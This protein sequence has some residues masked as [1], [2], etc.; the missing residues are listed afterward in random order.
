MDGFRDPRGLGGG[1]F[2]R[3]LGGRRR[4][5]R[6]ANRLVGLGL[7]PIRIAVAQDVEHD[8]H[9]R[10]EH[11][12]RDYLLALEEQQCRR[13]APGI[14]AQRRSHM[15]QRPDPEQIAQ[16]KRRNHDAVHRQSGRFELAHQRVHVAPA[17]RIGRRIRRLLGRSR[18][19]DVPLHVV[20][21]NRLGRVKGDF[22]A[23]RPIDQ[24]RQLARARLGQRKKP[25]LQA[26]QRSN[27]PQGGAVERGMEIGHVFFQ[28]GRKFRRARRHVGGVRHAGPPRHAAPAHLHHPQGID[29]QMHADDAAAVLFLKFR[30]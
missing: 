21:E 1:R 5:Q 4:G 6:R 19:S 27:H 24:V 30:R 23:E 9:A 11:A 15:G 7:R 3:R 16:R 18:G 13:I 14:Q 29:V 10:F 17:D 25:H 12:V 22:L 2:G 28:E 8:V 26:W 20:V